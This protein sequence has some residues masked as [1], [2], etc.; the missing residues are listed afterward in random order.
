MDKEEQQIQESPQ[1]ETQD[2]KTDTQSLEEEKAPED[3]IETE[4]PKESEKDEKIESKQTKEIQQEAEETEQAE[5]EQNDQTNPEQQEPLENQAE[6]PKSETE[7][8]QDNEDNEEKMTENPNSEEGTVE[9]KIEGETET[10]NPPN[11][12]QE[13]LANK[14]KFQPKHP[15]LLRENEAPNTGL[16]I[17]LLS[18]NFFIRPPMINTNGND[19]KKLR[20]D[21]FEQKLEEFD[22]IN[23]QEMFS[24]FSRKRQKL[25]KHCTKRGLVYPSIP[26]KQ[27]IFSKFVI[28]SGLLTVS[29]F[30]VIVSDFKHFEFTAGVDGLAYKG[31]LYTK[32]S[33]GSN[34]FLHLFNVHTQA[35]YTAEYSKEQH[36]HF[37]ARLNQIVVIKNLMNFFLKKYSNFSTLEPHRF[38]D[39]VLIAGDFNV[40]GN[41][42]PIPNV[43]DLHNLRAMEWMDK[44][45]EED[46][47]KLT[48]FNFL[49]EVLSGFGEDEVV[50]FLKESYGGELPATYGDIVE[51]E[52]VRKVVERHNVG[53]E[54]EIMVEKEVYAS[55]IEPR[56]TVLTDKAFY[57]SLQ[58]LDF[59]FQILPRKIQTQRLKANCKVRPFFVNNENVTQ[60]SDHYGVELIFQ[61]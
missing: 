33:I 2:S 12:M 52:R 43:F 22:I 20:I 34:K 59:V 39:I 6:D 10:E 28:D 9:L 38:K 7:E 1:T 46:P 19:Y 54:E 24:A 5:I 51:V 16:L 18:Y 3:P 49:L 13:L 53:T 23:F 4:E 31:V 29:K 50:D 11:P 41:G 26:P 17:R 61:V 15:E 27:P 48:E 21:L 8:I 44:T 55:A 58:C 42:K 40:D 37:Q 35:S 47:N 56:D 45:Y 32:L 14:P 57:G 30:K 25:L 60:L 36:A